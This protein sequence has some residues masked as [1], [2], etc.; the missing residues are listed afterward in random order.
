MTQKKY[1]YGAAVQGIQGFIFQTNTLAE[2][3]GA[4]ALVE[5]VCTKAFD[6]FAPGGANIIGAAGNIKHQFESRE[7]CEKAVLGFPRKIMEMAPG[8]TI[9][10]AVVEIDDSDNFGVCVEAL[11]QK[12][13]EQRNKPQVG[14]EQGL[15]ALK[16]APKTG[17]PAISSIKGELVD[18]STLS[19]RA[20]VDQDLLCEK[21]F[22]PEEVG[23][24]TFPKDISYMTGKNDW[25]AIVHADGNG[26][27]KVVQKVGKN[28]EEY[29]KFSQ[30][31]DLCT[32]NAAREAFRT[33]IY[34]DTTGTIR[35]AGD[36]K[37]KVVPIRPV[38]LGGDD[39]TLICRANIAIPYVETFMREFERQTE[40]RLG[41]TLKRNQ[42]FNGENKLTCCAGIA[43]IKSSYPFY[44]G[45]ELAET[46]CEQ[47][48]KDAKNDKLPE[49][50]LAPSCLM[51]HK[52]QDSF[53]EN[54]DE[55]RKRE[56][57]PGQNQSWENGPYYLHETDGR[58]TIEKLLGNIAYMEEEDR[59]GV[60]SGLRQW[61]SLMHD[62]P[63]K[64]EQKR[65]RML[66]LLDSDKE[67]CKMVEL[68][69][70][71]SRKGDTVQR[72]AAYD[73]LSLYTVS[74][75]TTRKK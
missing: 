66:S 30:E 75:K 3:I 10:Q 35:Q 55:I 27:G 32:K 4:S 18:N 68:L 12:L 20:A 39:L 38:I 70:T 46:L 54:F 48:K 25:I 16:R 21:A 29:R 50:G 7:D 37:E 2:I 69:S 43:F 14:L 5:D 63:G 41:E 56:L 49:S 23:K 8:I 13:R 26:L 60:R 61:M 47:A 65:Q 67:A 40:L 17:L 52:V 59:Q 72:Y 34:N 45:K 22:G 42:V 24:C 1:L 15:I 71:P 33:T 51:F 53:I 44:Y 11:E 31:L 19:K 74:Y 64:A 28:R 62:N 6:E 9:S 58:W 73:V 57:I 36:G